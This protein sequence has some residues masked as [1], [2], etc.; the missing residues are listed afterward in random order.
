MHYLIKDTEF[1]EIL[2]FLSQVKGIHKTDTDRLR[3]F[4]EAVCFIVRSGC[5]WRLLPYYYG[6]WRAVH[7]RFKEWSKRNIWL[8][9][10]EFAQK[11]PD[12]ELAIIDSTIVRAHA[13]A[14]GYGYNTQEQEALGRSKG[15]FSTKIHAHVD[16]LGNPIKFILTSGNRAEITQA[17]RLTEGVLDVPLI[18]D[19]AYGSK[20]FMNHL[21]SKACEP[22][23]PPRENST[24]PWSY[25]EH[26][27][28]ERHLI[29]CFFGKIKHFRRIF[30]RFDKSALS[31]LSFLHFV[32]ALIWF[33]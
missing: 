6:D 26:L 8:K 28:E 31:Y 13:C 27:Y 21:R 33:R 16:A 15:G 11:D 7:K 4:I 22:V 10:F 1:A 25:D 17:K 23:I 29:E 30:S 18:A 14:A 32:G 2:K 3:N 9:L 19:K 20:D 24:H 5:Q 12:M